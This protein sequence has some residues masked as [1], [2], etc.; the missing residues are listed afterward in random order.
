MKR[1]H[2]IIGAS[3]AIS[4]V[5][6]SGPGVMGQEEMVGLPPVEFR[7]HIECGPE[8]R[9]GSETWLPDAE[10]S[11]TG[12][13]RSRGYAW[14]PF[15]TAMSDPRLAGTYY[16]SY[17]WDEYRGDGAPVR[18]GAAT[19]RIENEEGAWQGSLTDAYLSDGEGA[20]ASTVL[21]GEGAYEGLIVLWEE[22]AHFDDCVWDV[23]GLIVE[24]A[25]PTAPEA[26]SDE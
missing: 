23:Q 21:I 1:S 26:F 6:G 19:W 16:V 15:T 22:V 2:S 20:S 13:F 18:I 17:E 8:V 7:G 14:N 5:A 12:V 11:D 25:A 3:I 9:T 4:L 24:G 10:G